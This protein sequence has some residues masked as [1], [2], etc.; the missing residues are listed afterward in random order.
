MRL[1]SWL[2][3]TAVYKSLIMIVS[4]VFLIEINCDVAMVMLWLLGLLL[5]DGVF[6]LAAI[7]VSLGAYHKVV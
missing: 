6:T 4:H 3:Y 1:I 5:G 7:S 2:V